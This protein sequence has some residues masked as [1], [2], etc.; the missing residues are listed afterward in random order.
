MPSLFMQN[1]KKSASLPCPFKN[2]EKALKHWLPFTV[3]WDKGS[4]DVLSPPGIFN[5][6]LHSMP[7]PPPWYRS[8]GESCHFAHLC[9]FPCFVLSPAWKSTCRV[10]LPLNTQDGHRC[11]IWK[12]KLWG[13]AY[14][15]QECPID[16]LMNDSW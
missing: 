11:L 15:Y 14:Q 9:C 2:G 8:K 10:S 3:V 4:S 6:N 13:E 16:A 7:P 1:P 12:F 5:L